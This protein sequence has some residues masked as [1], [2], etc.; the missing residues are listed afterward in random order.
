MP[1]L[2]LANLTNF[3]LLS[4]IV[5]FTYTFYEVYKKSDNYFSA[6]LIYMDD[7]ITNFI[8]YN[9]IFALS[10]YP[11]NKIRYHFLQ[12]LYFYLLCRSKRK[13]N[14]SKYLSL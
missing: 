9:L 3:Y 8:C 7:V 14:N 11:F 12:T 13:L 2:S 10:T 1:S 4:T 5:L 6:I